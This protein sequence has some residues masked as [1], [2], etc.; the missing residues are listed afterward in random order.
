MKDDVEMLSP[1]DVARE[2]LV[3]PATVR[4]WA[5]RGVLPVMRTPGGRRLFKREDV[6]RFLAHRRELTDGAVR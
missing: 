4:V 1:C 2:G 3:T 6:D 5:D